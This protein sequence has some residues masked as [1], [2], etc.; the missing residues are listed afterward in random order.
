MGRIRRAVGRRGDRMQ[1]KIEAEFNPDDLEDE[2]DDIKN[3]SRDFTS[4]F[5]RIEED[6]RK[7]WAGSFASNGLPVGGWAPLDAKYAAWKA[8]HFPGATMVRSGKLFKSLSERHGATSDIGR[9]DARFGTKIEYAKFHQMGTSKM[10]KR[11][12][13]YEPAEANLKWSG[14]V[15]DHLE[16]TGDG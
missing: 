8:T 2:L 16:G 7:H 14:W 1:L 3:R 15:K 12:L 10:P 6:L 5:S 11:Q 13:V 9:H 4:V